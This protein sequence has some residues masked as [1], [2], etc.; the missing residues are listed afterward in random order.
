[1]AV[2]TQGFTYGIPPNF[3][4]EAAR[5]AIPEAV[6]VGFGA[7]L[8]TINMTEKLLWT[9]DVPFPRQMT[10]SPLSLVS[11]SALDTVTGTGA[12]TV[13]VFGVNHLGT[14][15]AEVLA[16]NGTTPVVTAGSYAEPLFFVVLS[17]GSLNTNVGTITATK[18]DNAQ[19]WGK[20]NPSEGQCRYG[21]LVVPANRIAIVDGLQLNV[22]GLACVDIRV[23]IQGFVT[24]SGPTPPVLVFDQRVSGGT[25]YF[26]DLRHG[27]AI[28]PA[29]SR[30]AVTARNPYNNT[31]MF[32]AVNFTALF[33]PSSLF[34]RGNIPV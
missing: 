9:G 27:P 13:V 14:Q 17:G 15:V 7:S 32:A 29:L 1:M 26:V 3:Y 20:I 24:G 11:S 21:F 22:D 18:N 28:V 6:M 16:L 31:P 10:S 8:R 30:I 5:G 23:Y 33:A 2:P 34:I 19:L 25:N 12:R 4:V